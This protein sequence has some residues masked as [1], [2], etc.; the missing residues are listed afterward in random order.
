MA[1][2]RPCSSTTR[3]PVHRFPAKDKQQLADSDP[4]SGKAVL[5][6]RTDA[7]EEDPQAKKGGTV[8]AKHDKAASEPAGR[9]GKVPQDSA[10]GTAKSGRAWR[11]ATKE[12]PEDEALVLA[13]M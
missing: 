10:V 4:A 12:E 9:T 8:A 5:K 6:R 3:S 1:V 2:R 7:R 13:R 11:K